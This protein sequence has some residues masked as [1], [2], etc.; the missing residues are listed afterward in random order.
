MFY[1]AEAAL[2]A[3]DL[4]F[5]SHSAVIAAFGRRFAATE[6]VPRA[7][8]RYLIEAQDARHVGDY[9]AALSLSEDDVAVRVAR[10]GEF[11]EVIRRLLLA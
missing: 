11:L 7:L 1:A 10:A 9:E 6:H 2:L 4:S 8:H 3:E 5:S